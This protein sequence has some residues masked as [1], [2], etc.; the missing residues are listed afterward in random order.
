MTTHTG[1]TAATLSG[2]VDPPTFGKAMFGAALQLGTYAV[3]WS[4]TTAA[5]CLHAPIPCIMDLSRAD[6]W[7]RQVLV[8]IALAFLVWVASV[9]LA[10]GG[11]SDPSIVDRL[12]SILPIPYVW[13]AWLSVRARRG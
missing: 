1:S 12:W 8:T 3:V 9:L 11:T 10:H 7:G 4:R 2:T 13:H 6:P 5:P